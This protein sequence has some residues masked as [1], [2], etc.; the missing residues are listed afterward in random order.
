MI[1][2]GI[3][4]TPHALDAMRLRDVAQPQAL[5]GLGADLLEDGTLRIPTASTPCSAVPGQPVHL[6]WQPPGRM[7]PDRRHLLLVRTPAGQN[8]VI[9]GVAKSRVFTVLT[10]WDQ[11][12]TPHRWQSDRLVPT[13]LGRRALPPT[14]WYRTNGWDLIKEGR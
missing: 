5:F 8:L 12:Q 6:G 11:D 4:F 3:Y 14:Y 2:T 9:V 1:G 10:L 7:H 13:E